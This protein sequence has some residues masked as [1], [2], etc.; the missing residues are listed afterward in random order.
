MFIFGTLR[1][2]FNLPKYLFGLFQAFTL[3]LDK[4]VSNV[5]KPE[6]LDPYLVALGA[7][8]AHLVAKGFEPYLWD[9]F[10][11]AMLELAVD[12]QSSTSQK[13]DFAKM[14]AGKQAWQKIADYSIQ[15]MKDGYYAEVM[16]E[17]EKVEKI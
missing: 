5:D 13:F 14:E 16:K 9:T 15:K 1:Y 6:T 7:R 10:K 4:I 2:K 8:H 12:W 17:S 3:A 11:Q